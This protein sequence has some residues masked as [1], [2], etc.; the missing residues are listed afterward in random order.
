MQNAFDILQNAFGLLQNEIKRLQQENEELKKLQQKNEEIKI[1]Q[2][3]NE[4]LKQKILK[5]E[6]EKKF[7]RDL[8]YDGY[9]LSVCSKG[10]NTDRARY[11]I[12]KIK[13]LEKY[14]GVMHNG[15]TSK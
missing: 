8:L 15:Q 5:F 3:E 14:F 2:K 6:D 13:A 9:K 11:E 12:E 4:E 7:I 1:I 10:M